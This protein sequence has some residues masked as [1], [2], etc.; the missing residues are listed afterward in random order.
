M[1]G[2]IAEYPDADFVHIEVFTGLTDPDFVPDLSHIA[3]AVVA[4]AL[5]T[6]P[7]VFVVD[8]RGVI[9]ARFEGAMDPGELAA[10]LG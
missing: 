1:K 2:V 4:Y 10:Y 8:E 5:P 9:V 6:E 7:W 3:P